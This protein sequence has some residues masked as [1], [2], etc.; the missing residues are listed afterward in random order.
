ME[1]Q[2]LTL[3]QRIAAYR[4]RVHLSQDS[5]AELLEVSRQ[6]VSK[7]ETDASTPELS[8]L[9][10]LSQVFGV[11]LDE[12]V[13]GENAA[14]EAAPI[15]QRSVCA[16][17][18]QDTA[19][20]AEALRSH[21]QKLAGIILLAVGVVACFLQIGLII[22]I[23]PLLL[24]GLL[25]LIT[26][27]IS[28]LGIGLL[29]WLASVGTFYGHTSINLFMV[30]HRDVYGQMTLPLMIA[31]IQWGVLAALLA[32]SFSRFRSG[33]AGLPEWTEIGVMAAGWVMLTLYYQYAFGLRFYRSALFWLMV[34]V[35]G[36]M[37][38]LKLCRKK[39]KGE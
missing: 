10:R 11:S 38:L 9:V 30:F 15:A 37:V 24:I 6:S 8:K 19:V 20:M 33:K 1:E 21:R 4:T 28:G 17:L 18:P 31:W 23:W 14:E 22:L 13:I 36:L 12:L 7:W 5:L 16:S 26:R 25:C 35:L 3:G 29:L 39:P 2:K 27:R 34:A 32:V